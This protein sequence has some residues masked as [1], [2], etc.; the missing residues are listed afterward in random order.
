[1]KAVIERVAARVPLVL[2]RV[3][4]STDDALER[5]YGHDIPV[6]LVDG[7][8]AAKHRITEAELVRKLAAG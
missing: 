1:M 3:D 6:L 8:L 5:R 2:E 4:I 7:R